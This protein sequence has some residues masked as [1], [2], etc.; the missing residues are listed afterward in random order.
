MVDNVALFV[1]RYAA[2]DGQVFEGWDSTGVERTDQLPLSLV[3]T[4]SLYEPDPDGELVAGPEHTRMVS[5]P[6]RPFRLAPENA[7]D[8]A[9]GDDCGDGVSIT[10]CFEA[11]ASEISQAS[12]A[13]ASAISDARAQAGDGC[14]NPPEPS[15]ALQR[16]KVLLGGVPG[17]DAG[18]CQ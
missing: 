9:G 17:F 8:G 6:V 11:F 15:P 13:L 5:L 7:Q 12:P 4:L 3:F 10:E 2:E 14:W 16:L 18:E 1:V